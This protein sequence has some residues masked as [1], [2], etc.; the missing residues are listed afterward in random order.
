MEARKKLNSNSGSK[1]GNDKTSS[2]KQ[3]GFKTIKIQEESESDEED[4]KSEPQKSNGKQSK[5]GTSKLDRL[6]DDLLLE[7]QNASLETKLKNVEDLKANGNVLIKDGLYDRAIADYEKG[8]NIL[9]NIKL[10]GVS[11]DSDIELSDKKANLLNNIA[12]CY[13]QMDH[14]ETVVKYTSRIFELDNVNKNTL[15]KARLRRGKIYWL[16]FL[17][18]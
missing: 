12:Y 4:E 8:L 18:C 11:S 13:M 14:P 17:I 1:G 3:G 10:S 7:D 6:I 2:K 15:I 16:I 9:N 5:Q